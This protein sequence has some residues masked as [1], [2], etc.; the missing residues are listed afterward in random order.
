MPSRGSEAFPPKSETMEGEKK[1]VVPDPYPRIPTTGQ[2]A[3]Q[4]ITLTSQ[5]KRGYHRK[6]RGGW[7]FWI[8][9]LQNGGLLHRWRR[10][11]NLR[12]FQQRVRRQKA[13]ILHWPVWR[14]FRL[15]FSYLK[16]SISS[17]ISLAFSALSSFLHTFNSTVLLPSSIVIFSW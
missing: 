14:K 10:R 6:G 2:L 15:L 1:F 17:M 7:L 13:L 8:K 12:Y 4:L 11:L 16:S 9:W 5:D 3:S